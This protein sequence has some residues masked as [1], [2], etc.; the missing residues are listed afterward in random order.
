ML[1]GGPRPGQHPPHLARAKALAREAVPPT[2]V[3]FL[4]CSG[5]ARLKPGNAWTLA[6]ARVQPSSG[7]APRATSASARGPGAAYEALD[8]PGT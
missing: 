7:C 6:K 2:F 5:I 8:G 4:G 3:I 1:S